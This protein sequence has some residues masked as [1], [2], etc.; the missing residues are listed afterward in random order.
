M[1]DV[2]WLIPTAILCAAFS[3]VAGLW[4]GEKFMQREAIKRGFAEYDAETGEWKWRETQKE[5]Q[6]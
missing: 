3:F 4:H 6:V 2:G 5:P 1:I